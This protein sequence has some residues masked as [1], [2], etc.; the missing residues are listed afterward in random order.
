MGL[1]RR[2]YNP[3]QI[4]G[5]GVTTELR[6][7][8]AAQL[9][10][11]PIWDDVA[12]RWKPGGLVGANFRTASIA[13]DGVLLAFVVDDVTEI[14]ILQVFVG[15]QLYTEGVDYVK[16]DVTKTVTFIGVPPAAGQNVDIFYISA[17]QRLH[18]KFFAKEF[19]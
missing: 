19:E 15:G 11:A 16:D 7:P 10:L 12:K 4:A 3:Y 6:K 13:G 8:G 17:A 14:T 1:V 9:N 5:K 18:D 2:S